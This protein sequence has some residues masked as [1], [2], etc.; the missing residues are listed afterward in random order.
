MPPE[1]NCEQHSVPC[2]Q[3]LPSDLQSG[4]IGVHLPLSQLPPQHC[5]LLVQA[6]LSLVHAGG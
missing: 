1:Q 4:L 2:V 6:W 3:E 5:P